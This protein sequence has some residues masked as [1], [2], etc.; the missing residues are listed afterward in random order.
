M[1]ERTFALTGLVTVVTIAYLLRWLRPSK[2]QLTHIPTIGPSA[3]ILSYWG[4][5]QALTKGCELTRQGY[6]KYRGKAFKIA[7]FNKWLVIVSGPQL[8]DE[9]RRAP[10]DALSFLEATNETLEL[11]FTAGPNVADNSYHVATV[12]GQFTRA[13]TSLYPDIRDEVITACNDQLPPTDEWVSVVGY[14]TIM[15][16]VARTSSRVFVGLP[17]CRDPDYIAL[18]IQF[19]IDLVL[20][21]NLLR[22]FPH[23]LKPMV[24]RF[25]TRVPSSI[26]RGMKHL[27]PE[28][29]KRKEMVEQYGADYP[30]KPN[31]ILS[32]L[33][34]DADEEEG[35][36]RN[37]VL[38]ILVLDFAAIH[39][40]TMTFTH[41]LY[42]L[43]L[44]PE[45][46]KILRQEIDDVI[47]A[48]GW[49]KTAMG[50]MHKVDSFLKESQRMYSLG[51]VTMV[52]KAM[53]DFTFSDGTFIPE[54]TFVGSAVLPTQHEAEYYDD[55]D[56][57]SPWRFADARVREGD[58]GKHTMVSTS[59]EYHPFGHGRHACPGRFFAANEL[60]LMMVH[61]VTTY[62]IKLENEGVLPPT[63]N[64][65]T[66][67]MPNMKAKVLFRKRQS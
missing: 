53:K 10:D 61:L 9:L 40:S 8:I 28:I 19:T 18:S 64:F 36:V 14:D 50:K 55:P 11:R 67:L 16:I 63:M 27:E 25:L 44:N 48:E 6:Q 66:G 39:T 65:G 51:S 59:A 34:D 47:E 29:K 20:A 1:E 62:D 35:T 12:R 54:G 33:I 56:V 7:E 60:K 58:S 41:A 2:Y 26:E 45:Y 4:A 43:A 42:H 30:D 13:L 52:R 22:Q 31:D 17:I 21:S 24:A 5:F 46:A 15:Q 23:F 37:L 32:L 49:T 3:P 57:F 38:R